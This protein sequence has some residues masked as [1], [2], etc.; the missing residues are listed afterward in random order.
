MNVNRFIYFQSVYYLFQ[1]INITFFP[2]CLNICGNQ[3]FNTEQNHYDDCFHLLLYTQTKK[4]NFHKFFKG[5]LTSSGFFKFPKVECSFITS[6]PLS[7]SI[8]SSPGLL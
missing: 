1:T 5:S 7:E 2:R 3:N 4:Q 8:T 6:R